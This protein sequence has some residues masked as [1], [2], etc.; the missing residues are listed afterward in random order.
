MRIVC[1]YLD[2]VLQLVDVGHQA[3]RVAQIRLDLRCHVSHTLAH[4]HVAHVHVAHPVG[5]VHRAVATLHFHVAH[6]WLVLVLVLLLAQGL[7]KCTNE[8]WRR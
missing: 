3:G 2:G 6:R 8:V 7:C 4:V 1:S 5:V